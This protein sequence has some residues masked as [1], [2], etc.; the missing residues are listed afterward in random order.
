LVID[1]HGPQLPFELPHA[2]AEG[3]LFGSRQARTVS[4]RNKRNR[5]N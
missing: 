1:K 3:L 4:A 5:K 2:S